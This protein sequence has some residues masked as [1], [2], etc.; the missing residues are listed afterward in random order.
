MKNIFIKFVGFKNGEWGIVKSQNIMTK[1][2]NWP[3]ITVAAFLLPEFTSFISAKRLPEI[4]WLLKRSLSHQRRNR[5]TND[6]HFDLKTLTTLLW[7]MSSISAMKN[8]GRGTI[9]NEAITKKKM[10]VN[11]F[12]TLF[13]NNDLKGFFKIFFLQTFSRTFVSILIVPVFY[14][15]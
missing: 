14:S 9:K 4:D 15:Y 1:Y 5:L 11:H 2:W 7:L 12:A 6:L 13:Q 10:T 8:W 3:Q